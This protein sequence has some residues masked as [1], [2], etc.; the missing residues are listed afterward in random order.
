M[1]SPTPPI[2]TFSWRAG[3]VAGSPTRS[4]EPTRQRRRSWSPAPPPEQGVW[5][6]Q[7]VRAVAAAKALSWERGQPIERA[8]VEYATYG[9]IREIELTTRWKAMYRSAIDAV[10]SIDGPP[11]RVDN[12]TKCEP[13]EFR[14]ECG[15]KTRSRRSL[16]G[17]G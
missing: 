14:E 8:F 13:C 9:V 10:E 2:A 16:L 6:P 17:L 1:Q 11:A 4:W 12:R 7:S 3:S 5:Q 15:V